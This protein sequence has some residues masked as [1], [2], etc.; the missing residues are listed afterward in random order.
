MTAI[1]CEPSYW[2]QVVNAT[3][4]HDNRSII[5]TVPLGEA[6]PLTLNEV[7]FTNFEYILSAGSP[8]I[9]LRADIVDTFTQLVQ[10][11]RLH[12]AIGLEMT[13]MTPFM[14]FALATAKLPPFE[15]ANATTLASILKK[16]QQL[17][18]AL[19][20]QSLLTSG[21]ILESARPAMASYEL[22]AVVIVRPLAIAVEVTLAIIILLTMIL[23][24]LY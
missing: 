15:Y 9:S 22:Q 7:N 1:F 8:R 3:V 10:M 2:Q 14:E 16:A 21:E 24:H 18:F 13:T 23:L 19:A 6:T 11:W 20:M 4:R 17:L 5:R 12:E